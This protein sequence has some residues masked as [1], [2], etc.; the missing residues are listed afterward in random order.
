M[1]NETVLPDAPRAVRHLSLEAP[2]ATIA[3][4]VHG[5]LASATPERP[6]LLAIGSPMAAGGFAEIAARLDDRPVVTYDPR[7]AGRSTRHDVEPGVTPRSTPELHADDLARVIEALGVET[8]DVFASSGGAVNALALVAAHPHL[9]RTLVAHEP[10]L[11]EYV[12]DRAEVLA[13]NAA[14]ADAYQ[15]DG[16]GP[17]MARFLGLVMAQGPLPAGFADAAPDP[18]TFGLP[19][20]DD[21][22][23]DDPLLGQN[24]LTCVPYVPDVARLVAASTRVVVAA[25]E[26]SAELLT[27]RTARGLAAALGTEVTVFPSHHGG[28]VG[29][30]EGMPGKP[31]E[32]AA[33][34]REVLDGA[35]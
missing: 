24:V 13:V 25:G 31:A 33:R 15:R 4:D 14:M 16:F 19:T 17:A 1:T 22:R 9:L 5:D 35:R 18:A 26:E 23:R 30:G 34:L 32:F 6:V 21:G 2:G 3:Y 12:P 20:E 10:P 27:G 28:F 7:G 8:V 11:A 29:E